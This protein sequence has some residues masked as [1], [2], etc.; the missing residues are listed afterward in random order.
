MHRF[1]HEDTDILWSDHQRLADL[2][3][4]Q[5]NRSISRPESI[6]GEA[7]CGSVLRLLEQLSVAARD[8][9]VPVLSRGSGTANPRC[10]RE[11]EVRV[12][13]LNAMFR[14]K[15]RGVVG[16]DNRFIEQR[17]RESPQARIQ[18]VDDCHQLDVNTAQLHLADTPVQQ[19]AKRDDQPTEDQAVPDLESS[20]QRAGHVTTHRCRNRPRES[21]SPS[22]CSPDRDGFR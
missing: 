18:I 5:Q 15:W 8:D 1:A 22:R 20:S 14:W 4:L 19:N 10:F 3:V 16:G 13:L 6:G 2:P 11:V 12:Q 21:H 7:R 9:E 17:R